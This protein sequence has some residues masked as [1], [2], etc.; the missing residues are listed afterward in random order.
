[1]EDEQ[2]ADLLAEICRSA[3]EFMAASTGSLRRIRLSSGDIT[4]E[5]EWAEPAR[6]ASQ[7]GTAPAGTARP[8]GTAEQPD[9]PSLHYVRAELI[10]T[11]YR[12]PEP[13]APPFVKE[14][15]SVE[16][17]QQ[18]AILEAMKLMLPVEADR[19]GQVTEIYPADGSPVEYG[20]RL[21]AIALS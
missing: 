19:A 18:L 1:V 3:S 6:P 21:I 17:G 12:A 14:G 11:F 20:E 2:R 4:F 7:D 9:D 8:A 16:T 10:G 15:D 13:G 5:A